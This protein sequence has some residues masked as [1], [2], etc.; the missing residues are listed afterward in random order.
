MV[1]KWDHVYDLRDDAE[2]VRLLRQAGVDLP[3]PGGGRYGFGTDAWWAAVD[4]GAIT[5]RTLEGTIREVQRSSTTELVDYRIDTADG[6]DATCA[7]KGDPTRYVEGLAV[8]LAFVTVEHVV[9]T[10]ASEPPIEIITDVW[11]EHSHKRTPRRLHEFH[12]PPM[13]P[14]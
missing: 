7:F 9:D 14:I 10:S 2:H 1:K 13:P 5:R 6:A 3:G 11:I 4:S 8:R 12:P